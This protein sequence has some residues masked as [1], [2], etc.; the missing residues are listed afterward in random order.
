M[1]GG[2]KLNNLPVYETNDKSKI[3]FYGNY[4]LLTLEKDQL[5]RPNF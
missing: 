1:I 3:S 5:R 4:E 2:H